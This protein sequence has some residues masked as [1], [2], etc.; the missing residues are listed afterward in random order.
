[1]SMQYVYL[2]PGFFGFTSLGSMNY[3]LGVRETLETRLGEMGVRAVIHETDTLPTG[4][5]RQRAVRLLK[6]IEQD[7]AVKNGGGIHFV[8]HSTGGLDARLLVS[9]GVKLVPS[10]IEEEIGRRVYSVQTLSTPHY[11]TPLAGFFATIEGKHV[12][13]LL[14]M[15]ATTRPGRLGITATAK[16]LS[17]VAR[18]DNLTGKANTLLDPLSEQLIKIISMERGH[19]LWKFLNEISQDQGAVIQLAPESMDIFNAAVIN[20]EGVRYVSHISAS[21]PPF[22]EARL[23]NLNSLYAPLALLLYATVYKITARENRSY[24]YPV[25]KEE[26]RRALSSRLGLE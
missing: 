16:Y 6:R 5:I 26:D 7:G 2:V 1:M 3:F 24:P 4:S 17:L 21:P 15:L 12:L 25:L 8:G 14:T 13:H 22:K 11:G 18:L 20:R 10:D 23:S 19:Q 9:P